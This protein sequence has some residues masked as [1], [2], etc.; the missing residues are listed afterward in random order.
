MFVFYVIL[1]K[2]FE[3]MFIIVNKMFTKVDNS[4]A[5]NLTFN[6]PEEEAFSW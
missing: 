4:L 1:C 2:T 3:F 6:N 5:Y